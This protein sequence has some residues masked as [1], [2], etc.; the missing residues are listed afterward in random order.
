MREV[1]V[2]GPAVV[3]PP[4][5]EARLQDEQVAW[6]T[7]VRPD[8]APHLVPVWFLWDGASFLVFSKPAA[9]KVRNI[10]VE[11]RVM[12]AVGEPRDDFDVQLIEGQ[13]RLLNERAECYVDE[14]LTDKYG[15]WMSAIGLS[16][17]EYATTYSR[18]IRVV[19]TR[20]LDWRGRTGGRQ[21]GGGRPGARQSTAL[22]ARFAVRARESA[23][24]GASTAPAPRRMIPLRI[25][26]VSAQALRTPGVHPVPRTFSMAQSRACRGTSRSAAGRSRA[27]TTSIAEIRVVSRLAAWRSPARGRR[28]RSGQRAGRARPASRHR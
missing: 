10:A 9:R 24:T 17:E 26:Y 6:L 27:R 7:T 4:G 14:R 19:P 1:G 3:G 13:A 22:P 23:Q 20:F 21:L 2:P 11:G 15:A 25:T 12:L 8:G 5:L 18:V 16:L 28:P